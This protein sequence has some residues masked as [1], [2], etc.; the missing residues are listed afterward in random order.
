MVKVSLSLALWLPMRLLVS[1]PQHYPVSFHII[2]I[3]KMSKNAKPTVMPSG[4]SRLQSATM[5]T[6]LG[7][8]KGLTRSCFGRQ[9]ERV[10]ARSE[11]ASHRACLCISSIFVTFR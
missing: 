6:S 10:S 8:L 3:L 1:S 2:E 4:F 9:D 5:N 7:R 11:T